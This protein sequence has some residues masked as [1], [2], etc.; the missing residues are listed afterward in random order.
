[1]VAAA[2]AGLC[3]FLYLWG[4]GRLRLLASPRLLVGV[5]AFFVALAPV[6]YAYYVQFDLHPEL[7]VRGRTGV[8]GVR[9]ILLGQSADRFTGGHGQAGAHDYLF[10]YYTLLWAFLP[11]VPLLFAAWG[12]RLRGLW[13]GRLAALRGAEQLTFLGPL[14]YL[15]AL[16]LSAFKLDHYVNV[17][18][19]LLAVLAA[20]YA[21]AAARAGG[22]RLRVLTRLQDVVVVLLVLFTIAWNGLAF[23]VESGWVLLGAVPFAVALALAFRL[24]EPL[25][26]LW[27]PSA[28]A[29]L[30][31][32]F[33][34]NA[35]YFPQLSRLQPGAA[36]A[37]QARALPIDWSR[38]YFVG[39]IFQPFQF[40]TGRL[41]PNVD[42]AH[43]A[44]EVRAGA[45]AWALVSDAG[46]KRLEDAGLTV[47]PLLESPACRI[48]VVKWAMIDPRT[49]DTACPR[50][51]LVELRP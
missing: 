28:V 24:R 26:R 5:A 23:R 44:G 34:L 51:S 7:V 27:V 17:A 1:M 25:Q 45:P 11:W 47:R 38:F 49:R 15:S 6:L 2:L 9:F 13:R 40:Y 46:R 33:L 43:V 8:S 21:D 4:R 48:T 36:F 29:I 20:G 12:S 35:S 31:A 18:F 16:N 14:L 39:Q 19:P 42:A 3:L 30:L 22:R 37:A 32:N 10:F 50:A 41:V